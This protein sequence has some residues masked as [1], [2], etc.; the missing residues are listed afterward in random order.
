RF[1]A[2]S[3]RL[4]P[5]F[6]WAWGDSQIHFQDR[7]GDWWMPTNNGLLRFSPPARITDLANARPKAIYTMRDGLPNN[8]VLRLFEDSQGDIWIGVWRRLALWHRST[9]RIQSFS[10]SDGL[11]YVTE[12][13]PELGT[14]QAI[15]ED[16]TGQLWFGFHPFGVARLRN[17]RMEF[18]TE[19]DG[20]PKG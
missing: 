6:T 3:P 16:R 19:A 18:Y 7:Q 1:T 5:G 17:A 15:V 8:H 11:R 9:E 13:P 4:P 12:H 10:A 14:A 2:V 20:V